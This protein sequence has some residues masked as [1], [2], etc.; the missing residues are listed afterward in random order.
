MKKSV[1]WEDWPIVKTEFVFERKILI[2]FGN[3]RFHPI[4]NR[5]SGSPFSR[6]SLFRMS[7]RFTLVENLM[8]DKNS[9]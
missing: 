7:S 5:K 3:G 6:N 1:E 4:P 8:S 9:P 2:K